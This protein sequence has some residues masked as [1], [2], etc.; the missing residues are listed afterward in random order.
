MARRQQRISFTGGVPETQLPATINWCTL[1]KI[2]NSVIFVKVVK[3][4]KE[5]F[6][7]RNQRGKTETV[8]VKMIREIIIDTHA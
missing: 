6:E 3:T 1:V 7:I 8:P 5:E 4:G 2:D